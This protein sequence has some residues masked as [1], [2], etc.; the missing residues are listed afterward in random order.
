MEWSGQAEFVKQPLKEWTP[1]G[2]AAGTTRSYG[3]LTYVKVDGAGHLVGSCFTLSTP[4]A[5]SESQVPY[6]KPKEAL[7]LINAWIYGQVL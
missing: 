4:I 5:D 3:G 7:A 1:D 2:T 6:D